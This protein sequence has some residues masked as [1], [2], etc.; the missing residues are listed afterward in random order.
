MPYFY[1]TKCSVEFEMFYCAS[2]PDCNNCEQCELI[3]FLEISVP[4]RVDLENP[5]THTTMLK[6]IIKKHTGDLS[7]K[8]MITFS[9]LIKAEALL[10]LT[11]ES[12][13]HTAPSLQGLQGPA[14]TMTLL[15]RHSPPLGGRGLS[16]Q[17]EPADSTAI[18]EHCLYFPRIK[19]C[20]EFV[21]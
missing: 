13:M 14:V 4:R 12:P 19:C 10:F 6:K 16:R 5:A 9:S 8:H 17:P 20:I 15:R 1:L 2:M 3:P 11:W 18:S 7:F 21:V